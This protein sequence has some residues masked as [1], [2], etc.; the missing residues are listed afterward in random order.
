MKKTIIAIATLG[1]LLLAACSREDRPAGTSD[2]VVN[3]YNWAD[4]I[5][6]DTIARFEAEYGIKVNY[7]L[8]DS[9]EI[10]D[11]KLLAGNTGYDVVFHS[12]S[13]AT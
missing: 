7:D 13:Y 9:S 12:F 11:V 6:P 2:N 5:A 4:Y 8:Y 3:V 10:V 1:S